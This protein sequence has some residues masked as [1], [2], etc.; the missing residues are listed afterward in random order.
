MDMPCLAHI[1]PAI[2]KSSHTN[3]K[4]KWVNDLKTDPKAGYKRARRHTHATKEARSNTKTRTRIAPKQWTR[5]ELRRNQKRVLQLTPPTHL[6][7]KAL[8]HITPSSGLQ[9]LGEEICPPDP[10]RFRLCRSMS[11]GRKLPV[12]LIGRITPPSFQ[13]S[14]MPRLEVPTSTG[15]ISTSALWMAKPA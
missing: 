11:G 7:R 3:R 4:C 13:R 1:D 6:R 9:Q 10:E 15:T 8:V 14:A 2:G 12:R 5:M